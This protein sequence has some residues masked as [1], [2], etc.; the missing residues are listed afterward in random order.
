MAVMDLRQKRVLVT[1]GAGFLG[2]HVAHALRERGCAGIV[3]PAGGRTSTA[4]ASTG[5]RLPDLLADLVRRR[6]RYHRERY[7]G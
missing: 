7:G 2:Q 3:V 5:L 4:Q 6:D 1:G